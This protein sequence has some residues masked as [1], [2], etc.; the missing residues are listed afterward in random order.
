MAHRSRILWSLTLLLSSCNDERVG[1]TTFDPSLADDSGG[2][3]QGTASGSSPP[4]LRG[5]ETPLD[6]SESGSEA[7]SGSGAEGDTGTTDADLPVPRFDLGDGSS[8]VP[9][10]DALVCAPDLQSVVW[11]VSGR[12]HTACSGDEACYDAACIPAC[13]AAA[14]GKHA[15]GCEF[16]VPTPAFYQNEIALSGSPASADGACHAL[17]VANSWGR[18]ARLSLF[19]DGVEL[20]VGR[21]MWT[22][23]GVGE[24]EAYTPLED[25]FVPPGRTAIVLLSHRSGAA[26]PASYVPLECPREPAIAEDLAPHGTDRQRGFELLADTPVH[27]HDI[28]PFGGARSYLPSASLLYPVSAWGTNYVVVAP[29]PSGPPSEPAFPWFAI[30]AAEDDTTVTVHVDVPVFESATVETPATGG[31]TSYALDRGEVLQIMAEGDVTGSIVDADRPV[32]VHAGHTLLFKTSP[33]TWRTGGPGDAA[34]QQLPHVQQLAAR[35]VA[36]GIP[37]RRG[38]LRPEAVVYRLLAVV[39]ATEVAFEPAV[40]EPITLHAGE[41]FEFVTTSPFVVSGSAPFSFTQYMAGRMGSLGEQAT[42]LGCLPEDPPFACSLGDT[43]WIHL[44]APQHFSSRY[45]FA[46]DPTYGTTSVALIRDRRSVA[47]VTFS[48]GA[49]PAEWQ[50]LGESTFEVAYLDLFRTDGLPRPEACRSTHHTV[51]SDF[52]FGLV[53]WGLDRDASYGFSAAGALHTLNDL[54]IPAG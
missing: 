33:D 53:V 52:P 18:P 54:Q 7:G 29:V 13:E 25:G 10:D 4:P 28:L 47:P 14:L 34:H 20:D 22:V 39:D 37:T 3:L 46:L 32:A 36:P 48:C 44:T 12:V 31:A 19:Y 50:R 26:M 11:A 24:T 49:T 17:W 51:R 38:D 5:L 23:D 9:P 16:V 42:R 35:Y 43:D 1:S 8:E 27:V 2:S 41:S 21:H 6:A 40:H 15:L 30:T 45:V